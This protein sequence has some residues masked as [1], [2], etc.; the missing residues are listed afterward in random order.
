VNPNDALLWLQVV[1][2]LVQTG[3]VTLATVLGALN[4]V[5]GA[6]DSDTVAEDD[7]ALVALRAE[8]AARIAQA[9]ADATPPA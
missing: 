9:Q 6:T 4:R 2:V 7:A 5:R 1:A 3:Q 8:L